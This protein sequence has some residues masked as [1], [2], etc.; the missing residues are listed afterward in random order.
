MLA[1]LY[2]MNGESGVKSAKKAFDLEKNEICFSTMLV[3]MVQDKNFRD[4]LNCLDGFEINDL[5]MKDF[6]CLNVFNDWEH[7]KDIN[8]RDPR[9]EEVA[10]KLIKHLSSINEKSQAIQ[11]AERHIEYHG[12]STQIRTLLQSLIK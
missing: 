10:L 3:A 9:N 1:L 5:K 6:C 7:L 2:M 11:I 8:R 12:S 4:A